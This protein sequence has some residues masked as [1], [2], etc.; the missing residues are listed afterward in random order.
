MKVSLQRKIDR[1]AGTLICG[2]FSLFHRR[3]RDIHVHGKPLKILVI[4]LSEMGS[5]MLAWP[6]FDHI[7][8]SYP[9]SSIYVLLFKKNRE[10]LEILNIIHPTNIFTIGDS[11][12]LKL[13]KD[14]IGTLIKIRRNRIDTALDCELFSRISSI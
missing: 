1:I 2:I 11:S 12:I 4:L 8:K 5:L 6:M 9:N 13:L 10:F 7:K 3:G 14:S